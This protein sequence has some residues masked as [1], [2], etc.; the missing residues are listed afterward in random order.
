[1]KAAINGVPSLSVLD[2]WWIEGHVEDVTGWSIG[3][4]V[5]AC[6]D[7]G[8]GMD[9]CHAG[10]L[11]EKL[12]AKVAPCFYGDRSRFIGIMRHAIALNGAFFNTHRMM[13]Q[14]V[15]NAY[16]LPDGS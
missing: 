5:T 6:L 1:L 13:T 12:A 3:D 7:Q 4:S 11:Y 16:R 9:A 15:R 14:Y 8:S 2:G 10:A